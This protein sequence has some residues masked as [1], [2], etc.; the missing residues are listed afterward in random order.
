MFWT[1]W[2]LITFWKDIDGKFSVPVPVAVTVALPVNV[3]LLAN[4]LIDPL[5]TEVVALVNEFQ[6]AGTYHS[7]FS[8]DKL[9]LT[10]GTYFYTLRAGSFVQ[11]K[12][13]IL[14]K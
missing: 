11:T 13:M 8:I 4:A 1:V 9:Q 3:P 2:T 7:Q 14:I 5:I 12:K 6:Q 10:S